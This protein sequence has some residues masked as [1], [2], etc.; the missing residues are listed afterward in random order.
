M[1]NEEK[2]PPQQPQDDS[3]RR[4]LKYTGTAIGGVVVGGVVG[5]LIGANRKEDGK[6]KPPAPGASPATPAAES[7]RDYNQAFMFFNQ[8]Q[9]QIT[10]AA[11]ERLF[12]ADDLGPGAKELGV[13]FFIDH[14]LA[15]AYGTNARDYMMAP[16]YQAEAYQGY[17]MA[18]RR[19]ELFV[20]G[21]EALDG[22]SNNHYKKKFV[23]LTPEEQDAVLTAFESD[24]ADVKGV[25]AST[26]FSMMRSLTLEGVYSDPLY[27][28]NKNMGGWKMRNF[29]GNQMSYMD[30][31][32]KDGLVKMEPLSLHDHLTS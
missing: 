24:K 13:A 16:F 20:L 10:E 5:G 29:P 25:P 12:P 22:Y 7:D 3:R 1:A 15:S 14:Q 32:E 17:Q 18:F 27:G 19:R 30:A 11:T 23:K 8:N 2:R 6:T 26:F 28:G 21:L 4:F 31:I 9:F